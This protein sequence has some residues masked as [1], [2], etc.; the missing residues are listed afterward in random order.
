MWIAALAIIIWHS[1]K[2]DGSA[3]PASAL[4]GSAVVY[5]F[6]AAMSSIPLTASLGAIL[7]VGWT[8]SLAVKV[9]GS[10]PAATP[11]A[12]PQAKAPSASTAKAVSK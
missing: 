4:T 12:K 1:V 3:P 10:N 6:A 8:V 2:T 11:Q 7:A 9:F 5:S